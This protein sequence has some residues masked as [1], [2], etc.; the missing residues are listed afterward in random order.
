MLI[1]LEY[2][3]RV[4]QQ[5]D[6]R[7]ITG[8]IIIGRSSACTWPV[9]KEDKL[10]SSRHVSLTR[11][12][13]SVLLKDLESTN[14]TFFN[15]KRISSRKLAEGDKVSVGNCVLYAM[16]DTGISKKR[17]SELLVLS[18]RERNKKKKLV[19]PKFTVGSDPGS[20]LVFL[21]ML[22]S[23]NHAEIAVHEDGSCW[24]RDLNSKN[25]T[26]VNGVP[27]RS[28]KERL[29]KDG[30]KISFSQ[31]ETE[32][33]D[34]AVMRS[35][36]HIWLRLAI[37]LL[38]VV[39]AMGAYNLYRRLLPSAALYV[40]ETRKLAARE[41][42]EE[43][44]EMLLKA[45]TAHQ[46][47]AQQVEILQLQRRLELWG[48]TAV[49]WRETRE[50]LQQGQWTKVSRNLGQLQGEKS[51]AW[52]WNKRSTGERERSLYAKSMLDAR[53]R[54][55]AMLAR[56]SVAVDQLAA[57]TAEAE[58]LL[59]RAKAEDMPDY[60]QPLH[61]ELVTSH[62]QLQELLAEAQAVESAMDLLKEERPPFDRIVAAIERAAASE[63]RV[64]RNLASKLEPIIKGLAASSA[65]L[66][67]VIADVHALEGQRVL[68]SD[69]R[70]PSADACALDPR[71]STARQALERRH[72]N[73]RVQGTQAMVF[74]KAVEEL[75][76]REGA[77]LPHLG[78]FK[79]LAVMQNVFACD[80]L[81]KTLPRRSRK[82]PSGDYDRLLGIEEFYAHI[83]ALP[84]RL[85]PVLVS[86][87]A[88]KPL[89]T[90]AQE[91]WKKIDDFVAFVEKPE[92]AW[93]REGALQG[94]LERVKSF[95]VLR[96]GVVQI[97]V[98]KAS[99]S[100]GREALIAAGIACRMLSGE[101]AA[102]IGGKPVKD[103][104]LERFKEYRKE[105]LKLN[106]EFSAASL[107]QQVAIR[108]K[109]LSAGL[110]GDPVVRRMW[111][112]RDASRGK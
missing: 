101:T 25:G 53:S 48:R 112:M 18:G 63:K 66:E 17:Y 93:M 67:Q 81:D 108:D 43:A 75:I 86:D 104:V 58:E 74:F 12:G 4:I 94:Q 59:R 19:P 70:L 35:S 95:L 97:L 37:I 41:N 10:A 55:L 5:I 77:S 21:D 60:L 56:D 49:M 47:E 3:D 103:W 100:S 71:A 28:E 54:F 78:G 52:E 14:G 76:G 32:F 13:G 6:A 61:Q 30:D 38:T 98:T 23:R 102:T 2:N 110:P 7:E 84:E 42:F 62:L 107:E 96:N 40:A 45:E 80:S 73:V 33:H 111:A 1:R 44:R 20:S 72:V 105:M 88:F 99:V 51:E 82:E 46:A 109:V 91:L 79:D 36:S 68:D 22:I 8:E 69:L 89:L 106:D 64:I 29:L 83:D 26:S 16:P 9:P 27:L 24:L 87:I 39:L 65:I 50:L 34:G 11:H 90:Q 31:M 15:G 57:L 85:D 92:S